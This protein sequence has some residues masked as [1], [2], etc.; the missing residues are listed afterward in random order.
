MHP[1]VDQF[2]R[3]EYKLNVLYS[4]YKMLTNFTTKHKNIKTNAQESK[5]K[6]HNTMCQQV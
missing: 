5:I 1:C 2:D 3:L 6:K 4:M